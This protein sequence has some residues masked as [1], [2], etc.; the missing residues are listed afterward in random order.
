M[1]CI[2]KTSDSACSITA[3]KRAWPLTRYAFLPLFSHGT[4]PINPTDN[5]FSIQCKKE[6]V[7]DALKRTLRNF[8]NLLG[9]CLYDKEYAK[10]CLRSFIVT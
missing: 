3:G 7:T 8:G 5:N 9:N 10:V 4:T 1:V 2:M 6:A